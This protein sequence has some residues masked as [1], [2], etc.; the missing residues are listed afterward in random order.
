MNLLAGLLTGAFV[1]F[2]VGAAT[3]NLPT[4]VRPRGRPSSQISPRQLWLI[5]A[6]AELTPRQFLVGSMFAGLLTFSLLVSVIR[7]PAVAI[8]PAVV[9]ARRSHSERR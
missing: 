3:G 2:L 8:V 7:L 6:G 5:Q 1:Y 9:V 4:L